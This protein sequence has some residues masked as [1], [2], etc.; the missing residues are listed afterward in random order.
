M[1]EWISAKIVF[2]HENKELATD[3]ISDVFYSL[4]LKGLEI[5]DPNL[6]PEEAWGEGAGIVPLKARSHR[7]FSRHNANER[8]IK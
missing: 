3:L 6:V 1:M 4:G 8:E 2:E 7:V 5:E